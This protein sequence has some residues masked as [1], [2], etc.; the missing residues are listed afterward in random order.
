MAANQLRV[1]NS[2]YID[3]DRYDVAGIASLDAPANIEGRVLFAIVCPPSDKMPEVVTVEPIPTGALGWVTTYGTTFVRVRVTNPDHH[4]ARIVDGGTDALVSAN[5][6]PFEIL[7][8]DRA[9]YAGE[10]VLAFVRFPTATI[11]AGEG[12]A[13]RL[14]D[15]RDN[16]QDGFSMAVYASGGPPGLP[17]D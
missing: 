12:N 7:Q 11:V 1:R 10:A 8:R 15:H 5:D 3:L 13:L 9:N 6:G 16:N 4:Y 17:W 2:T 14:Q